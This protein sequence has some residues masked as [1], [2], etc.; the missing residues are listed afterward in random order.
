MQESN[1]VGIVEA[2]TAT[3]RDSVRLECGRDFA[4]ITVTYE[5]YGKLNENRSNAVLVLHAF[6]GDAHAAGYHRQE[7][8]YPGWW[9]HMI[10]P[11]KAFDTDTYFVICSN[12]LGGCQ[13]TSG[14]GS[15]NPETGRPYALSFPVV[16]IE[17]M[18]RVQARLLDHLGIDVLLAVAG[19]SMGGMQA[20]E[21]T[22]SFP[23][24]VRSAIVLASTARLSAQAI[25]FNAVGRNA[26]M[27]D[28]RWNQ[29]EYYGGELP[30]RGLAIARMV[31]HI[32]YLSDQS[33]GMKFG[34][35]L[36]ERERYGFDFSDQF[37]V[38]SYL[39][40]QGDKFVDRFDANS[41][42][43]LTKAIDYYDLAGRY[44]SLEEAFARTSAR[45]LVVS[46]SS[47]WLYPSYQ[48]KEIVFAL[49]KNGKDVSYTEI[50]SP[51]GHDSFLL[52]SERQTPL[53]TAFL[54][55]TYADA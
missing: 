27:S 45:F 39:E 17:D 9:D 49:T 22:V 5:T 3:F 31:G 29:G 50:S 35:K 6:S 12:V 28:P 23:E 36:Q 42:L 26:I 47:D 15:M 7:D 40:Y 41:Y 18:V 55:R 46:F 37:A 34:R 43:Y 24:R 19:G 14:P 4:P 33:M 16:T 48:S 21:W 8:S 54:E 51:Y 44:G 1:S 30:S 11:G 53:I 10:G 38:E 13:G 32:T 52:E 2:K 25:A 20:I